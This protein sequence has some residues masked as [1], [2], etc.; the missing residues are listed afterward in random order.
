MV[1]RALTLSRSMSFRRTLCPHCRKRLEPRQLIHPECIDGYAEAQAA[2]ALREEAKKARAAA[3]VER[4]ADRRRKEEGRKLYYYIHAA[5]KA[6]CAY[7]RARDRAAGFTCISSGRPLN[8]NVPN[9]VDAGHYRSKGAASHLRYNEDNCHA[10]SK[11]DNRFKA[12]NAVDYRI[13][14]I[15]RIG[16]ERVEALECNNELHEWEPEELIAIKKMYMAKL[17]EMQKNG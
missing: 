11:H 12:G 10:Q 13:R 5:D 2:K 7:I 15:D 16:L 1:L 17:K 8:W 4:A 3:K 9:Q 14:L 6:F